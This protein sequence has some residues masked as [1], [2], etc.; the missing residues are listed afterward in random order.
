MVPV[1]DLIVDVHAFEG[2][3]AA[4]TGIAGRHRNAAPAM[5]LVSALL[6]GITGCTILPGGTT[7]M[8]SDAEHP[9][10]GTRAA[11]AVRKDFYDTIDDT[12]KQTGLAVPSWNRATRN[13]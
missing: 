4:H 1:S 3:G 13:V 5:M 6:L 10:N 11:E 9:Y 2:A 7:P 12:I 8:K